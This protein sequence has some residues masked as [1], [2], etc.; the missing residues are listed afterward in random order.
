MSWPPL[1]LDLVASA[2][3]IGNRFDPRFPSLAC[4]ESFFAAWGPFFGPSVKRVQ[5]RK[6]ETETK[7]RQTCFELRRSVFDNTI[8]FRD[9]QLGS[10][11][12]GLPCNVFVGARALAIS[13]RRLASRVLI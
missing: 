11:M 8:K 7:R 12:A 6:C 10:A 1:A 5:R 2:L 9:F 3:V 4:T 13:L